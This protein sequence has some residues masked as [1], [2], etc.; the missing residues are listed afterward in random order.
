[1]QYTV[2]EAARQDRLK[3]TGTSDPGIGA[4][5]C[6]TGAVMNLCADIESLQRDTGFVPEYSFEKGI[7]ETID[8]LQSQAA[9]EK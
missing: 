2:L 6:P 3:I 5:P 1:M 7:K 4:R 9:G 8:W